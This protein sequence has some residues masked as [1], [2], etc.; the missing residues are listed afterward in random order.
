MAND[1]DRR[2]LRELVSLWIPLVFADFGYQVLS[3][4]DA[5]MMGR[6]SS[7]SLGGVGIANGI[8]FSILGL[9]MGVL[10]GM[11]TLVSQALGAGEEVR[12]RRI[13]RVGMRL[14]IY[15]S[16]PCAVIAYS[17]CYM[18][19]AFGVQDATAHAAQSYLLGRLANAM[20]FL[21]FI[22]MR[23]YLQAKHLTRPIVVSMLV[24][25]PLNFVGNALLIYGD[26]TLEWLG[27]SGIGLPA[28]G[29]FGGGLATSLASLASLVVL[30]VAIRKVSSPAPAD[31]SDERSIQS[32]IWK[33]GAP[34]GLQWIADI[35]LFA[36]IGVLPGRISEA[37]SAANQI[38]MTIATLT[39]GVSIGLSTAIS[40]RVGRH[41]GAGNTPGARQAGF[42]GLALACCALAA[43]GVVL[44]CVPHE[45]AHLFTDDPIVLDQAVPVVRVMAI[46]QLAEGAQLACAG[47]LR[48]V[49][50]TRYPFLVMMVTHYVVSLPVALWLG[51]GMEL[52]TPGLWIGLVSGLALAAVV[53]GVR[54][55]RLSSRPIQRV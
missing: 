46:C 54:F 21:V 7:A 35:S 11:D 4:A 3:F 25:V 40:V 24:V 14:A 43:I 16:I 50:D 48:G 17:V 30:G 5:A 15:L 39:T 55:A 44:L 6:F 22:A 19:P 51:F 34:A 12:A 29:P 9:A 10:M 31:S 18:L 41:V 23:S 36:V 38:G 33:L 53:L 28:L 8:F 52:G 26:R 32:G 1:R 47:A 20:P 45:V 49:G 37:A 2:E 27:M 42:L 13:L